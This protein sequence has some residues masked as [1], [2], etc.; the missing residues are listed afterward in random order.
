VANITGNIINGRAIR[1]SAGIVNMIGNITGSTIC[2]IIDDGGGDLRYTTSI[3]YFYGNINALSNISVIF[4]KKIYLYTNQVISWEFKTNNIS[5][6]KTLYSSGVPLGNP[7][8]NN[9]KI[10]VVYGGN[11]ELTGNMNVPPAESV[12]A[13]VFVGNT[14]GTATLNAEEMWNYNMNNSMNQPNT[15]GYKIKKMQPQFVSNVGNI[16]I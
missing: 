12:T 3:T 11:N 7:N 2:S 16:V 14:V 9:V 5:V 8:I 10:G 15:V 6:N 1:N 4:Q 13:G